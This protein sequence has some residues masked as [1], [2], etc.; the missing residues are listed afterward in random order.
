MSYSLKP[1]IVALETYDSGEI[2]PSETFF[3]MRSSSISQNRS[4]SLPKSRRISLFE[5]QVRIMSHFGTS[6][7]RF[8]PN[9]Y[10]IHL[11]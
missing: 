10:L 8:I 9:P 11:S 7:T 6:K 3:M 2:K 4:A 1:K 5:R